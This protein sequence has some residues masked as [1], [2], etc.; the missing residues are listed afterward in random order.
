VCYESCFPLIVR[1]LVEN[2]AELLAVI[3]NTGGFKDTYIPIFHLYHGRM[4]AIENH[5]YFLHSSMV[6]P[7]AIIDPEGKV[8]DRA[9]TDEVKILEGEVV[10][11][12]GLTIYDQLGDMLGF[13]LILLG[14]GVFWTCGSSKSYG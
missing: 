7:S 11:E 4:R 9:G 3:T 10:L 2:G 13:A 12:R 8:M 1:K 5:R 14:L 6:G